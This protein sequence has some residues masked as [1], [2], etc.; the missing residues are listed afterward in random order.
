MRPR[1]DDGAFADLGLFAA[2]LGAAHRDA[3]DPRRYAQLS[4]RAVS[5]HCGPGTAGLLCPE[6]PVAANRLEAVRPLHRGAFACAVAPFE[7]DLRAGTPG[8]RAL[9]AEPAAGRRQFPAGAGPRLPADRFLLLRTRLPGRAG[10]VSGRCRLLFLRDH[11]DPAGG[12]AD[13]L[14]VH[15]GERLVGGALA[16][17]TRHRG[18]RLDARRAR[19]LLL[20]RVFVPLPQHGALPFAIAFVHR[21]LADDALHP[22]T[23]ARQRA[24]EDLPGGPFEVGG[25]GGGLLLPDHAG[26]AGGRDEVLR[27]LVPPR[28]HP[29]PRVRLRG[30]PFAADPLRPRQAGAE[31]AA[32]QALLPEQVRLPC[33]MAGTHREALHLPKRGRTGEKGAP[34]LLRDL[35]GAGGG[36]VPAP[37][38][39]RLV[40]R[41]LNPRTGA[42]CRDRRGR[43]P[44]SQLA[45]GEA[46]GLLQQRQESR[47]QGGGL[48]VPGTLRHL[49]RRS[50]VRGGGAFRL[51]RAGGAGGARRAVPLRGLRPDEDHRAPGVGRH[52]A[53]APL[54]AAHPGQGDGGGGE[55]GDLR[56]ARPEEPGGDR[57]AGAGERAGAHRQPRV[58]A[59][60]AE[61]PR[62]HHQEDAPPD[63]TPAQPGRERAVAETT[64]GPAG[65]HQQ[66]RRDGAGEGDFGTG[67]PAGRHGGQGGTAEGA[68]EPV[69][70]RGGGIRTRCPHSGGSRVQRRPVHQGNR[71][72]LR[73][74]AALHQKRSVRAVSQLETD[75]SRDRSVPVAP[76]RRGARR[77][78]RG[79]ERRGGRDGLHR[80]PARFPG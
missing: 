76:D 60:H 31:G 63:R 12:G 11:P 2:G 68:A 26:G 19:L 48:A 8:T 79:V 6:R 65:A 38:G 28:P 25:H 57:L 53:S 72:W 33:P 54:R 7:P 36:A 50:P 51:H 75:R 23:L 46:V 62:Q 43:Q 34:R 22:L 32:A 44:D 5:R 10:A 24:G 1:G 77:Q 20:A 29:E 45:A 41:L 4:R 55:P 56:G 73:H 80:A 58:P 64:G 69:P 17:E 18:A 15:P 47:T 42:T 71:P 59:G 9:P 13:Q 67:K 70:E 40:L 39:V 78:D 37:E 14:R 35:R 27:P 49:L 3:G 74:V 21:R 66:L 61:Q 52:A 16:G 30:I